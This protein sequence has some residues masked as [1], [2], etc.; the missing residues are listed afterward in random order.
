MPAYHQLL[1]VWLQLHPLGRFVLPLLPA[2]KLHMLPAGDGEALDGC[3][4]ILQEARRRAVPGALTVLYMP[5]LEA[6]AAA[7]VGRCNQNQ[8]LHDLFRTV[9]K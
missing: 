1:Q 4:T 3:T 8:N 2:D 7:L 9:I 5:R 6:W